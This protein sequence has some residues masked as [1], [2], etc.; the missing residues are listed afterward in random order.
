MKRDLFNFNIP[1]MLFKA[2]LGALIIGSGIVY[3]MDTFLPKSN[4]A[5]ATI[6]LRIE[7]I[8]KKTT[9]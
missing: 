4:P 5:Y 1:V 2:V 9:K 3:A 7:S 6:D 8:A